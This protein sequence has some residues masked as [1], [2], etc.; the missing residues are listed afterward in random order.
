MAAPRYSKT[1]PVPPPIADPGEQGEDDVLGADAGRQPAVD[2][3]LVGLR[4]ALE[5]ALGREDHL[6]LAGADPER[7][8]PERAVRGRVRVAA[9]DR[10]ARLRQP[11]LRAR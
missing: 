10:H 8:R 1:C 7:E 5:Q 4:P 2:P 9:H 11:E 3:D 6:D